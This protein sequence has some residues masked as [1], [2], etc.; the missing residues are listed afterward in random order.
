MP[1]RRRHARIGDTRRL[2]RVDH[3]IRRGSRFFLPHATN[4]SPEQR[5][6]ARLPHRQFLLKLRQI[7]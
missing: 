2:F 5:G 3:R 1:A 7:H 4:R 6:A